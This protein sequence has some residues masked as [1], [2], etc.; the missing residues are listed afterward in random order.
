MYRNLSLFGEAA[1]RRALTAFIDHH[2]QEET[3]Q[4]RTICCC[5]PSL[6]LKQVREAQSVVASG[7]VAYSITTTVKPEIVPVWSK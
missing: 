5:P 2:H 3:T 1:L 7:S 4:A 6:Y